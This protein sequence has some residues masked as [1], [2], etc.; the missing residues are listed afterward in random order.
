LSHTFQGSTVRV[1]RID[2]PAAG[3]SGEEAGGGAGAG[4]G[5]GGSRG[6][7]LQRELAGKSCRTEVPGIYFLTDSAQLLPPSRP[8]VESIA[9]LLKAQA[10]WTVTIEGHT[11]STGGDEHNLALSRRRA[12]S[13]RKELVEHYGIAASRLATVGYGDTRPVDTNETLEGRAHN[14][15]VELARGCA[16]TA[17]GGNGT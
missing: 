12:E 10:T 7:R 16:T 14:R 6:D 11:D 15:R 8:A 17:T 1:V 9:A 4:A 3:T 13:L 2:R 5:A